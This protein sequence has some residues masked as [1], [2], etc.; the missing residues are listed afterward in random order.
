[1]K[2]LAINCGL[3]GSSGSLMLNILK[4]CKS[5]GDQ[6]LACTAD[7]IQCV[8]GIDN[9]CFTSNVSRT[10]NRIV[11]KI[12]GSDGFR[13]K[14]DTKRLIRKIVSYKPDL[15]H[16]HTI[17]GYCINLR[18]LTDFLK[19]NKIKTVFTLHDCFYFTGRCAH[20][21]AQN[22]EGWRQKCKKCR[23]RTFYPKSYLI[24]KAHA[25]FELKSKCLNSDLFSFVAVSKWLKDLA[26]ESEILRKQKVMYIYNGINLN[27]FANH[28]KINSNIKIILSV[29]NPWQE[30]K[31][32]SLINNIAKELNPAE[33]KV[34]VIGDTKKVNFVSC[35]EQLPTCQNQDLVKYYQEIIYHMMYKVVLNLSYHQLQL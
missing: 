32:V 12:D 7:S 35:I 29:A 13:N 8:D 6:V 21:T 1:M 11:T 3:S 9:F 34:L 2:I 18:I 24:D 27:L 28:N 33:Y 16:I 22:C 26:S 4:Y 17:H 25:F 23:Y 30:S 5:K 19:M 31:G 15:I 10:I 14:S 20:F